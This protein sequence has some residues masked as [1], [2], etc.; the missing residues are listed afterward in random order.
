ML[1]DF[2]SW[3][4]SEELFWTLTFRRFKVYRE[5]ASKKQKG[6]R[7]LLIMNAWYTAMLSRQEKIDPLDKYLPDTKKVDLTEDEKNKLLA[8]ALSDFGSSIR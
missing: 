7:D 3:G 1:S 8:S 4:Y 5:A 6:E 2:I